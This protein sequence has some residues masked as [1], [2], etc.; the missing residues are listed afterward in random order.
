MELRHIDIANLTVSAANMRG[1]GKVDTANI[2]PSVRARGILVSL[3]VR[4]NGPPDHSSSARSSGAT[5]RNIDVAGFS[6]DA[7][8]GAGRWIDFIEN[9]DALRL[10]YQGHTWEHLGADLR[11]A[12]RTLQA[13]SQRRS[14]F[15]CTDAAQI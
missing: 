6:F 7:I 11:R 1:K 12:C 8:K 13:V 4:P 15:F 14:R 3:L 2:L 5:T 9:F 10:R